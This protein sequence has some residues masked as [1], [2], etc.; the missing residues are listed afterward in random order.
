MQDFG[1]D[2]DQAVK[3]SLYK[4]VVNNN[5]EI[6]DFKDARFPRQIDEVKIWSRPNGKSL[7]QQIGV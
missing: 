5:G 3:V 1:T 4:L 6:G 7:N 2:L